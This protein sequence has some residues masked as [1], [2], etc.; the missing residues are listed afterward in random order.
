MTTW[1]NLGDIMLREICQSQEDEHYMIHLYE[2]FKM[3]K[4]VQA[5]N[6]T[7]FA[8]VGGR[9]RENREFL[10]NRYKISVFQDG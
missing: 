3:V 2:I 6:R 5:E 8:R 4:C 9:G 7:M 10:F 1:M